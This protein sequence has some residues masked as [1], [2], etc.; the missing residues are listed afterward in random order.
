MKGKK[1]IA[2]L[3]SASVICAG[4]VV[5]GDYLEVE[6]ETEK[7]ATEEMYQNR[8]VIKRRMDYLDRGLVA[9]P[10]ADGVLVSWRFLGTDSQYT[11]YNL[12]RNGEKINEKPIPGTNF[13]DKSAM[14]GDKYSLLE[15]EA[16][17]ETEKEA[18]AIAWDKQYIEF[19][20]KEYEV[21]D[22]K[23]DDATVGD[24]DGDGQFELILR[25]IPAD[26]SVE[27][28]V[29]YPIFE[30]YELTGEHIWTINA[31][32]N[33]INEHDMNMMVYDFNGDGKSELIMRSFE[34]TVDGTGNAI[35]DANGNITDYSKDSSNLAIFSDRQYIVSTPEYLSMYD[36]ETGTEIAR[37]DLLP[38]QKPLTEWSYS[39]KDN[40]RL[41]KRASQHN[42]GLAYLD[43][44]TPGFV[45]VR[46]A[47][48]NVRAAAWHIEDNKFVLD[49][50]ANTPNKEDVNSIYGAMNHNLCVTDVDFDGKDEI[51]SGP[52]AIDDDGSTLYAVKASDADGNAVKLGHGDA[53]D[54]AKMSP[55][56]NG[57][58]TW[59]CHETP[60]LPANIEL[61][62]SRTGQ[63][64]FGYEK[65]KDTGRSRA[66][67]I[68]PNYR[69][70]EVWG[71]TATIP[72]NIGGEQLAA[73]WNR[74]QVRLPDGTIEN[75][76]ASLPMN[77]K[78]YWDGDL[79]SEFL[80]DIRI[81]KWNWE[82]KV[83]DVL[84]D[85]EGCA[86]NGST[87]AVPC[88]AAD[89]FGDWR[90]EVI[91][92]TADESAIRI[93]STNIETPYRI[94][95]P[96]HDYYYR[97]SIAMQ[98][99]HYNQPANVSYYLGYETEHLPV[100]EMYAL[101]GDEVLINSDIDRDYD[102]VPV[103]EAVIEAE[104]SDGKIS[105]QLSGVD[106][107]AQIYIALYCNGRLVSAKQG[108]LQGSF[109]CDL[110][111]EYTIK[112]FNWDGMEPLDLV[113]QKDI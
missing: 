18:T 76:K 69:G 73:A 68:D 39:Y 15:L 2:M 44:E 90:D 40:G 4:T 48:D 5:Y 67:D 19:A 108:E 22:Y 113:M 24:L 13:L 1:L 91:W 52:M 104:K 29:A 100:S 50:V 72:M 43:G 12:Y 112:V 9:V 99:N 31:G 35:T 60:N 17:K 80:D 77:F 83:I 62:D 56:F 8:P 111:G 64:I 25:R 37:T 36:G 10:G 23:I 7:S 61:H 59:A 46:G 87:K 106:C 66:A 57:Y 95:T 97:A 20:V 53:F 102:V 45:E 41:T 30:A 81:S 74:F 88:V 65:S 58:Y 51:L 55:D 96:M 16:G 78:I 33:E 28:R 93:Y 42:F 3:L 92:K 75:S 101:N 32:P 86:S 84:F 103:D 63:V 98:N 110:E 94:Q 54:V 14:P 49:W 71:S 6:N 105:Y 47:W 82:D 85:A 89:L 34:G 79:L 38:S 21:G 11:R 27:T 70:Y 109:E 107:D 26:M